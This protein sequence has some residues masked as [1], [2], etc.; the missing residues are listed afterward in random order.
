MLDDHRASHANPQPLTYACDYPNCQSVFSQYARLQRHKSKFHTSRTFSC[1]ADDC[2]SPAFQTFS[3]LT[4]HIRTNHAPR[5][6]FECKL[7]ARQVR[8]APALARHIVAC[9]NG[10]LTREH[11]CGY[12]DCGAVYS[13]SG[14]LGTHI[15][16]KHTNP[17]GFGCDTC[18]KRFSLK[19]SMERHKRTIHADDKHTC[20]VCK[21]TLFG[22]E[23]LRTHML[24]N[25]N[26]HQPASP[27]PSV[28]NKPPMV[29]DAPLHP[30]SVERTN[31]VSHRNSAVAQANAEANA[32]HTYAER[33]KV[34]NF[35]AQPPPP[36]VSMG[37]PNQPAPFTIA[38]QSKQA[39]IGDEP[40]AS[41]CP[42]ISGLRMGLGLESRTYDERGQPER[43][44]P[45]SHQLASFQLELSTIGRLTGT[46]TPMFEPSF[47]P[48]NNSLRGFD[49]HGQPALRVH[50]QVDKHG[51][52][53]HDV[54]PS[55]IST[56]FA[57]DDNTP[58][59]S[60]QNCVVNYGTMPGIEGSTV[61]RQAGL[62][63]R[64]RYAPQ[65]RRSQVDPNETNELMYRTQSQ[66]PP[67]FPN[68][69]KVSSLALGASNP[70]L[71]DF[72]VTNSA[73]VETYYGDSRDLIP[74]ESMPANSSIRDEALVQ[75]GHTEPREPAPTQRANSSENRGADR[76]GYRVMTTARA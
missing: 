71:Q 67:V 47:G 44:V 63:H 49:N 69:S 7:C 65:E 1:L 17:G 30:Q 50:G 52:A 26:V 46:K 53:R 72:F 41:Q 39:L 37:I 32:N 6:T 29:L 51:S 48:F 57:Q 55:A 21:T 43:S 18:N 25:H 59:M 35:T 24:E 64:H 31:F 70:S 19:S 62:D 27:V 66:V 73:P 16:S 15:R 23:Q 2:S 12:P 61:D 54:S 42:P 14:N 8:S 22:E 9:E 5:K 45:T 38:H 68:Q 13:S 56:L 33:D 20:F 36:G 40:N 60:P 28:V 76:L 74:Q 75:R 11:R 34:V 58:A 3:D 10:S 4:R